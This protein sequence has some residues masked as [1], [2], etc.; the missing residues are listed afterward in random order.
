[1]N[2][3]LQRLERNARECVEDAYDRPLTDEEWKAAKEHLL[4]LAQLARDWHQSGHHRPE[5]T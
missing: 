5:E 1:M 2:A 4:R 3:D